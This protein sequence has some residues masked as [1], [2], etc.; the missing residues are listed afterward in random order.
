MADEPVRQRIEMACP[1]CGS[2]QLEPALVISTHCRAC[3]AHFQVRDGKG[4]PRNIQTARF[5]V[6]R[7]ET[8]PHNGVLPPLASPALTLRKGPTTPPPRSFLMRLLNPTKPPRHI[9]CFNCG[10]GFQTSGEA[11]ST[12]CPKCSGYVSLLNYEI[13]ERWNRAVETSGDVVIHKSGAVSGATIRCH[14][15]TV[16]GTLSGTVECSGDLIIRTNGKIIGDMRCQNLRVE[17]KSRIEFLHPVTATSA[18][19]DGT[20]RGQIS[21]SGSVTLEKK[22]HLQ[23]LVRTSSLVLKSGAKHT[24]SIEMIGPAQNF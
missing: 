14:H 6:P 19:I 20:V 9:N 16:L 10:H 1:V 17:K 15:L 23:G 4:V 5:A 11:Q 24:G 7:T 12:Q 13:T 18:T 21:C 8:E 22:A 3:R 2:I